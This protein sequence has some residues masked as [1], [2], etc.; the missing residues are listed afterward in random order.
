MYNHMHI[1]ERHGDTLQEGWKNYYISKI[2]VIYNNISVV[3][4]G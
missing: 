1:G 2:L 4:A 3:Y